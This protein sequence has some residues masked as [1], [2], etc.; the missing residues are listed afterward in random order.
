[1]Q[2]KCRKNTESNIQLKKVNYNLIKERKNHAFR[3]SN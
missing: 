1:M 3:N 2:E